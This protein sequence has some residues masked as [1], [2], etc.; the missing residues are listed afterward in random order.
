MQSEL[1]NG[2]ATVSLLQHSN[3]VDD[4]GEESRDLDHDLGLVRERERKK[5]RRGR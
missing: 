2:F 4:F 5:G 1:R 3:S